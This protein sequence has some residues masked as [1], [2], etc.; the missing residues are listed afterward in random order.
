MVI[1]LIIISRLSSPTRR[2]R[3]RKPHEMRPPEGVLLMSGQHAKLRG[4]SIHASF[5]LLQTLTPDL[6]KLQHAQGWK[7]HVYG[8][9]TF[10]VARGKLGYGRCS[11]APMM[12]CWLLLL[13]LLLL[14][15]LLS[16]W[17]QNRWPLREPGV[18]TTDYVMHTIYK[19]V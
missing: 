10:D 14:S 15:W 1:R 8:S 18:L 5:V 3:R 12:C 6:Q 7:W 11:T 2:T 16:L 13:A 19:Q 9:G 17:V 4:I